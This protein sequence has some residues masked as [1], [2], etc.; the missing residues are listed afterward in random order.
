VEHIYGRTLLAVVPSS[1]DTD[2]MVNGSPVL[3]A[4]VME[5]F[6]SL[7]TNIELATLGHALRTIAVTSAVKGEGKSTV[8]RNLALAYQEG[9]FR[10]VIIDADLRAPTIGRL[11]GVARSPG[12]TDVILGS[13]QL[14]DVLQAA[15]VSV[16]RGG[17]PAR[18]LF[19]R[20][21]GRTDPDTVSEVGPV[22]VLASGPEPA[23]PP[24]LLG[25]TRMEA[26]LEL[27][28]E[29]FDL[30]IV[31]TPPLLAVSDAL[32]LLA[33]V[34]GTV[35]VARVNHVRQDAA[36][37]LAELLTRSPDARILG[38]VANDV[39]GGVFGKQYPYYYSGYPSGDS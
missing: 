38:T 21:P 35:I 10:V 4:S 2:A 25:S 17:P 28:A 26:L 18:G 1:D 19:R 39:S 23:N 8:A 6:R 16:A 9:G 36:E 33:K 7:R 31:D 27:L 34:D 3:A 12:L 13:S 22:T 29:R 5:T 24:A 11:F 30:V 15:P 14:D 32:P 20:G 37:R